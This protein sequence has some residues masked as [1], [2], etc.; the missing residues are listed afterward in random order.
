[1]SVVCAFVCG[2]SGLANKVLWRKRIVSFTA[3]D[4]LLLFPI[5]CRIPRCPQN[6]WS[7]LQASSRLRVSQF[8]LRCGPV[9]EPS[10]SGKMGGK[11]YCKMQGKADAGSSG[12]QVQ[13]RRSC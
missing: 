9:V 5:T 2:V 6:L 8:H 13:G 4:S 3:R 1:M 10:I 11:R 12:V 7:L